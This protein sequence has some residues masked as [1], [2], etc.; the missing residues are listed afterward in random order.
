[1]SKKITSF[2]ILLTLLLGA[3]AFAVITPNDSYFG[4]QWYLSRIKADKAW[5][6]L[7]SSPDI[8]IAVIDSGVDISHPDLKN[9]IWQNDK[10]IPGNGIDDDWNGFIDDYNG[11]DFSDNTPDPS[12]KFISGWTESGVSHGTIVAGIIAAE[13]NNNRGIT[14]LSWK[15]KIMPLK[16]LNDK[17]EGRIGDVIRAIDYAANN[18][19]DIINL[20]FMNFTYSESLQAAVRRAHKAG[21]MIVAAAGN[22]QN[23]AGHDTKEVP[24]YPACYDG[25]LVGENM[26][27]GVAATDAL[28]QK[29]KFSSYGEN[30]VDISAPGISF[31]STISEGGSKEKP[32]LLYDG[33][34]SGTSMAAPLVSAAL[35]LISQA[36]PELSRQEIVSILFASSDDISRL[37]PDYQNKLGNGR[38]NVDRA[39]EMA[40]QKLYSRFGSLLVIPQSTKDK[41]SFDLR[42]PGGGIIKTLE[43]EIFKG[44]SAVKSADFDGDGNHELVLGAAAGFE[45]KIKI[46]SSDGRLKKEFLAYGK[47]EKG[48]LSL[49]IG[50]VDGDGAVEILCV[51]NKNGNGRLKIFSSE[52]KLKKEIAAYDRSWKG[53][54]NL[55]TGNLDGKG[56]DEIAVSFGWGG[57]PSVRIISGGGKLI[58]A[59]YAYEKSFRGGVEIIIGNL[60]GRRSGDKDEIIVVP[61]SAKEAQVK[62]FDDHGSL[63]KQF[64]AY[65]K[66]WRG[67]AN[68][69]VGDLNNDGMS[70]IALGA[71]AG[72]APHV[73]VFDMQGLL[74]ESFYAWD[75]NFA[76]GVNLNALK[77]KN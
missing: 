17:G 29:A 46:I 31:F 42:T 38:L 64:L 67:G 43:P 32:N 71:K 45:P 3:P 22:E 54:V 1:M 18:G 58:G 73:R 70:E 30:C 41:Q 13:G 44:F 37:N 2:L 57:S 14:G 63:L 68:I 76:G 25:T 49:A 8:V 33:Y 20:S 6:K 27:I 19:A 53:E 12:P 50:D 28:D 39:L 23:G 51:L 47:N 35:A 16:A 77:I 34:W 66:N 69:T 24:I 48:G 11:W 62:I 72:A 4:N 56:A 55:A 52:G 61:S 7:S 21:V 65:N 10:E 5:E 74:L 40:K 60:D 15:A 59:F 75:E 36:N 9:N 26:V